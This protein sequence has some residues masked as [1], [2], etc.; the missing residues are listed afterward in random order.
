M[1]A[2][3]REQSLNIIAKTSTTQAELA[4]LSKIDSGQF[5]RFLKLAGEVGLSAEAA[6]RLEKALSGLEPPPYKLPTGFASTLARKLRDRQLILF[7]GAGLSHLCPPIPP[8]QKRLPLWRDLAE[9]VCARFH[10]DG[11]EVSLEDFGGDL[12]ALFDYLSKR[13]N[14]KSRLEMAVRDLLDTSKVSLSKSHELI[15]DLP[16]AEVWTTNYDDLLEQSFQR[17]RLG[18]AWK[19][20]DG[21]AEYLHIREYK[22]H[23]KPF[24]L[25]LHGSLSNPHTL[26]KQ[27]Y[28]DWMGKNEKVLSHI[29][30]ELLNRTILFA[31]YGLGDPHLD[32]IL[33]WLRKVTE[34]SNIKMYGLFHRLSKP[35]IQQLADEQIEA[36]SLSEPAHWAQAF[37]QITALYRQQAASQPLVRKVVMEAGDDDYGRK[38]LAEALRNRWDDSG[39]AHLYLT[40]PSPVHV[41]VDDIFVMPDLF[42]PAS[43]TH[44]AFEDDQRDI[45]TGESKAVEDAEPPRPSAYARARAEWRLQIEQRT[46]AASVI[47]QQQKLVILGGPGSGKSL[48]LRQTARLAVAEW[49]QRKGRLP[50]YLRL[51]GWAGQSSLHSEDRLL[52]ALQEQLT[53][54][55]LVKLPGWAEVSREQVSR[56]L[57]QGVLWLLD[58]IDEIRDPAQ[59][60]QFRDA[61]QALARARPQDAFVLTSRPLGYS[62]PFDASWQLQ[63]LCPFDDAQVKQALAAWQR[64]GETLGDLPIDATALD[65]GMRSQPSLTTMRGTPLLLTLAVLFY[66][67][68][69]RLPTN[70]W[71]YYESTDRI[72]RGQWLY[73]RVR[74]V[75]DGIGDKEWGAL[76]GKIAISGFTASQS[77]VRFNEAALKNAVGAHYLSLGLDYLRIQQQVERFIRDASDLIGV[78]VAIAPGDYAFLHLSFQEYHAAKHLLTLPEA[79]LSRIAA[80]EWDNPDWAEVWNL[81]CAGAAQSS[82]LHLVQCLCQ[83]A[84][85]NPQPWCMSSRLEHE[86][87]ILHWVAE[88]G[89]QTLSLLAVNETVAPLLLAL[90]GDDRDASVDAALNLGAIAQA[91]PVQGALL[92]A[93]NNEDSLVRWAAAESLSAAAHIPPVQRGLFVALK[94]EDASVSRVAARA[95]GTIAHTEPMRQEL[96]A[97]LKDEDGNM[98]QFA[99]IALSNVAHFAAVQQALLAALNDNDIKVRAEAAGALHGR[100]QNVLVQRALLKTM[101][102]KS[103]DVRRDALW[104]LSSVV[105]NENVQQALIEA[106]KDDDS[107]VREAA[108]DGL[109]AIADDPAVQKALLAVIKD[110]NFEVRWAAAMALRKVAH[111]ETVQQALLAALKEDDGNM[112]WTACRALGSVAQAAPV[113]MALLAALKDEDSGIRGGAADA[114]SDVAHAEP[115]Q[116]ALMTALKDKDSYVRCISTAAL[117]S[118]APN[119]VVQQA[120][121]VAIKD[122]DSDVRRAACTSMSVIAHVQPVR[123]ALIL[124][125]EDENNDVRWAASEA[126]RPHARAARLARNPPTSV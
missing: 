88:A 13:E 112:R 114:L 115:V 67:T 25:H 116:Q 37:E 3:L 83:A 61:V 105:Q 118:A 71:D 100:A 85:D 87:A 84:A 38:R 22:K 93:L 6:K 91:E 120:L 9:Q 64:L 21:E 26:T 44:K 34:G 79:E 56:W 54:E 82:R 7:A 41:G 53:Q 94:D 27:Q 11:D 58:G 5:S 36:A 29:R 109:N 20:V 70:R 65:E 42:V 69:K 86:Q 35:L 126:L 110:Q 107:R 75:A 119:A 98:R 99:A 46:P 52:A 95:L 48:L 4:E 17:Y 23:N 2:Q 66:R 72:L 81:F 78:I 43:E 74:E 108:V 76:L 111:L 101:H 117:A 30:S 104:A 39:V 90:E 28:R 31:G 49:A 92:G 32:Q 77:H 62:A 123:T 10:T 122:D 96:L 124:A 50:Y 73:H 12:L 63:S 103:N 24:V 16:W 45:P 18:D 51:N 102:D 68:N 97:A 60:S 15:A 121:L 113:Q 19:M 1:L 40:G 8:H 106:V 59:R 14:G 33:S 47:A 57:G 89:P 55:L 125:L 80:R